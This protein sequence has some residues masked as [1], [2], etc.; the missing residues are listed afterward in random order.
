MVA[1]LCYAQ[2]EPK[3]TQYVVP[4]ERTGRSFVVELEDEP[5]Y[6]VLFVVGDFACNA[7][8]ELGNIVV[9]DLEM[10]TPG[11]GHNFV[12]TAVGFHMSA[13]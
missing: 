4:E 13:V 6:I 7:A 1:L 3:S 12:D 2:V 10:L 9:G 11:D 5:L 8:P